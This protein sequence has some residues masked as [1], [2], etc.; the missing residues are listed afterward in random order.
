MNSRTT[1]QSFGFLLGDPFVGA[2]VEQIEREGAAVEHLVVEFADV[3]LGAQFFP[4][5][6]AEFANLELPKFVAE[7]LRR[8]CDVAVGLG[9]DRRL[10]NRAGLAE[11]IYDLIAAPSLG[12]DS[13]IHHETH[14]A[15]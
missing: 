10:V 8:P 14:R 5:T 1:Q 15:E 4:G 6:F 11:E 13:G 3:K 9:L 7:G 2:G 12:V